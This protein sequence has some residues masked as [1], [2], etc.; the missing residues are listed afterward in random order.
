VYS[1]RELGAIIDKTNLSGV[2]E[3]DVGVEITNGCD[4]TPAA[5]PSFML[6]VTVTAE[7]S[8]AVG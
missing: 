6:P 4:T 8:L 2:T 1:L 3:Q 5:G 7:A